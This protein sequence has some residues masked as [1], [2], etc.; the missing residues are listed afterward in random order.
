[1]I[2]AL[3]SLETAA[4]EFANRCFPTLSRLKAILLISKC[5]G[6]QTI[7]LK[8]LETILPYFRLWWF[9]PP[10]ICHARISRGVR[11]KSAAFVKSPRASHSTA[12]FLCL[13][14]GIVLFAAIVPFLTMAASP[15]FAVVSPNGL[16]A[17]DSG[18]TKVVVSSCSSGL[19]ARIVHLLPGSRAKVGDQVLFGMK[20][21]SPMN[22]SGSAVDPEDGA[23]YSGTMM[24]SG[25]VLTISGCVLGGVICKHLIW[26][27]VK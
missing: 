2:V 18:A 5:H 16:W 23:R 11:N 24:L 4:N 10:P 3:E 19:C 7:K 15:A 20:Q 27:R 25:D 14:M 6:V 12:I 1:M 21:T 26:S 9:L 13:R 17:R 8:Q 22:W